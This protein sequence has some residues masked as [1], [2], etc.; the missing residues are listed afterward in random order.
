MPP[1]L[2]AARLA[3]TKGDLSRQSVSK[4]KLGPSLPQG[5]RLGDHAKTPNWLVDAQIS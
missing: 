3:L 4:F 2:A 5:H 1:V